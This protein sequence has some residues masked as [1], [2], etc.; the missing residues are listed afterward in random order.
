VVVATKGKLKD[1]LFDLLVECQAMGTRVDWLPEFYERLYQRV[2]MEQIDPSWALYMMQNRPAFSRIE[3]TIKRIL[4]LMFCLLLMPVL[5]VIL[6][7]VAL[8]IKLD[9]PGPVFYRQ[10]RCGRAGRLYK[11]FKFRTMVAN[12][13][14]D[15]KA[16]WASDDDQRITRVGKF[17]R[18]CRLDELPQ[19]LNVLRG[20]MSLVGP[21][22]ERPEFV[23]ELEEEIRYYRMRFLV[24]P[25]ITG[26]AQI[27]HE[28]GNTIEHARVKLQYDLYYVRYWSILQDI[29]ILFKTI[30]VM[31]QL[32]GI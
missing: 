15:G 19:L 14:G 7:P 25:G 6:L 30:G 3:L 4:D 26:W 16:R 27:N 28:Y 5:L 22:P 17:L 24:K 1:K 18:K 31:F 32:K 2:P 8:A 10:V 23:E 20:D 11:I 29:Y 9:S 21:R 13:E 12:A